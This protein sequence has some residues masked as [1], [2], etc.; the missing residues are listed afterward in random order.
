MRHTAARAALLVCA[1]LLLFAGRARA[2]TFTFSTGNPDGKMATGSRPG[3]SSVLEI[4]SADDFA[5]V[6]Q[7]TI[8]HATFF[9]LIPS[10]STISQVIVEIYRVFPQ[11]STN[12][13]SGNVTTRVNSPSDVAFASRD[14]AAATLSFTSSTLAPSFTASN[15]VLN[16]INKLPGE[17]TGGEGPVTG[18]EVQ[19]DVTFSTTITLAAGHYF[20]VPQVALTSGDFFWL[21][22]P[23]PIVAPG[24]PFAPD[25]QSWIRNENLAPDW[26]RIGTDIVGGAPAPSFN[27]A[28]S[29]SGTALASV[30]VSALDITSSEGSAF[31]G[32]VATFTDNDTGQPASNFTA[33][34]AWGD[35]A[36]TAGTVTGAAG[37]FS[38]SGAHT[39]AD[40][41]TFTTNV[42]V[43]DLANA[44]SGSSTAAA[45]IQE[46][47]VL[48]GTGLPIAAVQGLTF[49]GAVANFSDTDT[50]NVASDFTAT[51]QWGDATTTAGV[52]SGSAGNFTVSGSHT[53]TG[54]GT[55]PVTVT[56]ADDAPGTATATAVG[57]ASVAP[58]SA[59]AIPNL[60]GLGRLALILSL[61]AA[62][63]FTLL[64]R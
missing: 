4:E 20:F 9:G 19:I 55:F 27:G 1:L 63:V 33:T 51:I 44:V 37:S 2:L 12:P 60:G 56:L 15:S 29:L 34:I 59:A 22:A 54:T 48:A 25:L 18:Q 43:T 3:A 7:T 31:S 47:D 52:V 46:S 36:S 13:P 61:A 50:A 24:T 62:A 14:S 30:A 21:S 8:D 38:V 11:D 42:S 5:L 41:G 32:A 45:T 40:E 23:K 28:F 26:L 10:V 49:A 17:T 57:S 53:Y 39:Y 58:G 64:R 16:G 6:S 35:G